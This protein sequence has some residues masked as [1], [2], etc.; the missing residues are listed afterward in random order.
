MSTINTGNFLKI[1]I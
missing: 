1:V